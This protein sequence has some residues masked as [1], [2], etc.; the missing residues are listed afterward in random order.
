MLTGDVPF[1]AS[2]PQAM[3]ARRFTE[4]AKRVRELRDTVPV[5]VEAAVAKALARP[6]ADRFATAEAVGRARARTGGAGGAVGAAGR[7][8]GAPEPGPEGA[9]RRMAA[10]AGGVAVRAR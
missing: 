1:A 7:G 5:P 2:T 9:R 8:G 10:A 3:I 6:P 4:T